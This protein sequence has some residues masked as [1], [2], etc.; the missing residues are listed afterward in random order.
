MREKWFYDTGERIT[1]MTPSMFRSIP[2]NKRPT[3]FNA[4][5]RAAKAASGDSSIP[6]GVY[7]FGV[8]WKEDIAKSFS[9]HL[10]SPLNL[11]YNGISNLGIT[12]LSRS[13]KLA[14]Q[15]DLNPEDF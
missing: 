9:K 13:N 5:I 11:G 14:F 4:P 6:N 2:I 3:K 10:S 8:E 12:H 7:L 15:E 1:C